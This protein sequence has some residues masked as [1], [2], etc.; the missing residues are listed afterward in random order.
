MKTAIS[1]PDDVFALVEDFAKRRN[2]SR[3]ALFTAAVKEYVQHHRVQ[4][5]TQALN[6]VYDEEDSSLDPVLARLQSQS[7]ATEEW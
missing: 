5:V 6:A 2:I 1:I 7:L 4:G 3:S